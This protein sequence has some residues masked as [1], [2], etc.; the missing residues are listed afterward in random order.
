MKKIYKL[1]CLLLAM[2]LMC[3]IFTACGVAKNYKCKHCGEKMEAY[4]SYHNGYVCWK[5]NK[6]YYK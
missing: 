5:C 1:L 4:Y 6:K 3:L 2:I